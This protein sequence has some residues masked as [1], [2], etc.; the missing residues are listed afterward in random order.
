MLSNISVHLWWTSGLVW[1]PTPATRGMHEPV[2]S[3][4]WS[5]AC[6]KGRVTSGKSIRCKTC[7]GDPEGE[8]LKEGG[9][10]D[11]LLV[12][13]LFLQICEFLYFFGFTI[14]F[15]EI[16]FVYNNFFGLFFIYQEEHQGWPNSHPRE[17]SWTV[18]GFSLRLIIHLFQHSCFYCI[19][20]FSS[21]GNFFNS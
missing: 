4:C 19:K 15:I 11:I 17:Y 14:E 12:H 10:T 3:Q 20:I 21:N 9:A 5:Q 7:C 1:E 2:H 8:Q 6:K 13:Y 18:D 16:W